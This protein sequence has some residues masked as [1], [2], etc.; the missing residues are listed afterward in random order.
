MR[1]IGHLP[2][3]TSASRFSDFLCLQ[4]ISNLIEVEKDG[5]AI[6][7]HSEDEIHKARDFLLAYLGNPQEARFQKA[8]RQAKLLSERSNVEES[9]EQNEAPTKVFVISITP[10]TM[11]L[12]LASVAIYL[13]PKLALEDDWIRKLFISDH[14]RLLPEIARGE[15]WRLFT[16]ILI[17]PGGLMHLAINLLW[18]FDLGGMIERRQGS[19]RLSLLVLGLAA[20]SNLTQYY[21]AGPQFGGLSGVVFGL[22]GYIWIRG[23]V[24]PASGLSI[25]P[26]IVILMLV[27]FFLCFTPLPFMVAGVKIANGAH[28]AGLI[29]GMIAG[30]LSGLRKLARE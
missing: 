8:S 6:W 17:H 4:G 19:T 25:H 16:P 12:A 14:P 1:L 29:A 18:F 21:I 2:N 10:V 20:V 5:C 7:I 22:L 23:R 11:L 9:R 26:H 27:W 3:E 28:A 13:V 30:Y 15:F 24:D